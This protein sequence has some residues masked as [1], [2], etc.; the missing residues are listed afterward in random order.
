MP[1][2]A[3]LGSVG[4]VMFGGCLC[5]PDAEDNGPVVGVT[6]DVPVV[7]LGRALPF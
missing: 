2:V 3:C 5:G 4:S 1:L 7:D 6:T